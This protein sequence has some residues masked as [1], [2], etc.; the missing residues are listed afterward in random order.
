MEREEIG[1]T[2]MEKS[3][4]RCEGRRLVPRCRWVCKQKRSY[5][6]HGRNGV[7][8]ERTCNTR[9]ACNRSL[10]SGKQAAGKPHNAFCRCWRKCVLRRGGT[11]GGKRGHRKGIFRGRVCAEWQYHKR[12]DSSNNA[13]ICGIQEVR[14][15][16]GREYE[17]SF[18]RGLCGNFGV[19]NTFCSVRRRL[20]TYKGQDRFDNQSVR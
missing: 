10:E 6:R 7:W 8:P 9:N 15:L 11:L 19:C 14:H 18:L 13:Q 17:Y 1:N 16:R 5:E 3:V 2:R 20:G 12:A 4:R